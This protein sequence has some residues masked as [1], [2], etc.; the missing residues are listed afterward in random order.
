MIGVT[1]M[2]VGSNWMDNRNTHWLTFRGLELNNPHHHHQRVKTLLVFSET[3]SCSFLLH[4]EVFQAQ[5]HILWVTQVA[6]RSWHLITTNNSKI[7]I[8]LINQINVFWLYL[9]T[10]STPRGKLLNIPY[11]HQFTKAVRVKLSSK[12][13][14]QPYWLIEKGHTNQQRWIIW[15]ENK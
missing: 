6:G 4:P 12:T 14:R 11:V 15:C 10:P 2:D 7:S 9:W 5:S 1:K 13:R 8:N 3:L